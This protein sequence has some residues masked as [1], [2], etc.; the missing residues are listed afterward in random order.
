MPRA[1]RAQMKLVKLGDR[2][3]T[4]A[5]IS[6]SVQAFGEDQPPVHAVVPDRWHCAHGLDRGY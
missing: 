2:M 4:L 6:F 3:T 5:S 1:A